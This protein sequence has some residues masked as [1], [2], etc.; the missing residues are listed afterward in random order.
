MSEF[1]NSKPQ[2]ENYLFP[3]SFKLMMSRI[4]GVIYNCQTANIPGVSVTEVSTN[5]PRSGRTLKLPSQN[6]AFED[7]QIKFLVDETMHNWLEIY[8]WLQALRVVDDW[9]SVRPFAKNMIRESGSQLDEGIMFVFSS[10]NNVVRKFKFHNMF[11]KELSSL[12]FDSGTDN[13]EAMTATTTF[14]FE[15]FTVE[16]A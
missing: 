13:P 5:N 12:D 11:P 15:Y 14:A 1:D 2:V 16:S 10:A 7:L 3:T 8:N 6:L 4:P 9:E